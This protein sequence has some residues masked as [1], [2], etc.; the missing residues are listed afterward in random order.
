MKKTLLALLFATL[1]LSLASAQPMPGGPNQP[2]ME[3]NAAIRQQVIDNTIAELNKNYVFPEKAKKMEAALRQ[4]QK[5]GE[6]NNVTS[7]LKLSDLLTEHLVSETN[8]KH[9]RVMYSAQPLPEQGADKKP[10][11]DQRA[12]EL[13]DMKKSNFGVERVERL[14]FNIGYLDLRGFLPAKEAGEAIAAAMT[15]VANTDALIIDLRK[16]GGGDPATVALLASYL[17]DERTHLN[18]IFYRESNRTEQMWS[19]DFVPGTR[20]GKDK[21]VYVLTSQH[22]FSAAEDFS[23]SLQKLKRV[24]VVG[25]TTGGGAHPGD[26]MR[27]TPHFGIFVPN[28]RSINPI[29]K[30]DWEGTGV[31]PDIKSTAEDALKTAQVVI[32]KKVTAQEKNPGRVARIEGRI[33]KVLAEDTSNV[34]AR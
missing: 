18:D 25:E 33:A 34:M 28:G 24:T 31:S 2:D 20:F 14:P 32:L 1:G 5:R 10:S 22:T 29:T 6:Y 17:F 16:N 26:V 7:A 23:Y 12:N 3:V 21:E 9:L 8:D 11:P 4:H 30:T 19:T 13:L 15:L 27:L